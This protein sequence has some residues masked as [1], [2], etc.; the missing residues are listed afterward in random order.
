MRLVTLLVSVMI[1]VHLMGCF[2]YYEAKLDDFQP[3]TWV[4]RSVKLLIKCINNF[5]FIK[6]QHD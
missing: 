5:Y 3:D 2:W 1:L 4:A 6:K